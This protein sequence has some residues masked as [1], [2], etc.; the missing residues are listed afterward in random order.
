MSLSLSLSLSLSRSLSLSLSLSL[1]SLSLYRTGREGGK[2][3]LK[4]LYNKEATVVKKHESMAIRITKER[5]DILK[6]MTGKGVSMK[7]VDLA[8][9]LSGENGVLVHIEIPAIYSS[10]QKSN[11]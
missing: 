10:A 9:N 6:K 4:G 2:N 3:G 11:R 8:E 7:I 5:L 1:P